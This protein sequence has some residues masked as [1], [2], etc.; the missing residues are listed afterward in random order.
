[1]KTA[2]LLIL[3]AFS[4]TGTKKPSGSSP[5][6]LMIEFIREPH[7]VLICDPKPE[8]S[9]I[10]PDV[11][12]RQTAYQIL[13]SSSKELLSRDIGDLWN[14]LK[15]AGSQSTE[16]EYSGASLPAHSVCHWK[17]RIWDGNGNTTDWSKPA[18]FGTGLQNEEDWNASYIGFPVKPGSDQ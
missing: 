7:H 16:V 11:A 15:T 14:G 12:G 10:V 17:V 13:V 18:V 6:G 2:F 4:L 1:M 3:L 8:F 5:S 9:W